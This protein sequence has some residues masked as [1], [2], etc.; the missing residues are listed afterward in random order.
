[1]R[2]KND[3]SEVTLRNRRPATRLPFILESFIESQAETN[4]FV[5]SQFRRYDIPFSNIINQE[6]IRVN[7]RLAQHKEINLM[8]VQNFGRRLFIDHGLHLNRMGKKLLSKNIAD[9]INNWFCNKSQLH[10]QNSNNEKWNRLSEEETLSSDHN[11]SVK[12]TALPN[13]I[14]MTGTEYCGRK[15]EEYCY[16]ENNHQ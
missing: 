9:S 6:S 12:V 2:E 5:V 10:N 14:K 13:V 16:T 11:A 3:V 15:Y 1:M 8:N 7:K 4:G